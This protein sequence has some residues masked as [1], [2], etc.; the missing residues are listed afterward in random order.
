MRVVSDDHFNQDLILGNWCLTLVACL[1]L[2]VVEAPT[3]EHLRPLVENAT[4]ARHQ[5]PNTKETAVVV[6]HF[7][8]HR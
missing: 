7:T 5:V 1:Y 8:P 2:A 3:K 6:A 4:L